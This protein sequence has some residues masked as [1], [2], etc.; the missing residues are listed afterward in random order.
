MREELGKA[1]GGLGTSHF[2]AQHPKPESVLRRVC[3]ALRML[4]VFEVIL[5]FSSCSSPCIC[6][7]GKEKVK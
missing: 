6:L 1:D 4:H 2:L 3:P 5:R 7:V